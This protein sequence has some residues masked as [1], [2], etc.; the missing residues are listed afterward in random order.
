MWDLNL[1]ED[2]DELQR[3]HIRN[4]PSCLFESPPSDEFSSLVHTRSSY[5]RGQ[6]E[7]RITSSSSRDSL[8]HTDEAMVAAAVN[9]VGVWW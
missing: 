8:R 1:E 9:L 2:K 4:R 7:M 6:D 5:E 3:S